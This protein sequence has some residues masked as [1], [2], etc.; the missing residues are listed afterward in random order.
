MRV[1]VTGEEK[2]HQE[3]EE[4]RRTQSLEAIESSST[5]KW[6]ARYME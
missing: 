6:V 1:G 3:G 4:G 5:N 2:T